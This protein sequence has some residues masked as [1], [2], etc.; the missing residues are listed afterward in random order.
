M[1]CI[2]VGTSPPV[3]FVGAPTHPTDI[4]TIKTTDDFFNK[5]TYLFY[6][7]IKH[8][9]AKHCWWNIPFEWFNPCFLLNWWESWCP[10]VHWTPYFYE[11]GIRKVLIHPQHVFNTRFWL[12]VYL[13][14]WKMMEFVSWNYYSQYLE[15][16][17][18]PWFQTTNQ[19]VVWLLNT[20]HRT[21]CFASLGIPGWW[22]QRNIRWKIWR[23]W[24]YHQKMMET[25]GNP[26]TFL[27]MFW[28]C[29]DVFSPNC[30]LLRQISPYIACFRIP[31]TIQTHPK[32]C[33][34]RPYN[35]R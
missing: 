21:C 15:S 33:C 12:V 11:N 20:A 32:T 19:Q 25:I 23:P 31:K 2:F 24:I 13:P 1:W 28:T 18:I 22:V 30:A 10:V 6:P 4:S 35:S 7:L 34:D 8:E 3:I 26:T 29:P 5:P 16:H 17:K 14:L 9:S 27:D